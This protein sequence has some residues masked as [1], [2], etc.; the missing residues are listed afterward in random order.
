MVSFQ[1]EPSP[2]GSVSML[3][4]CRGLI[5]DGSN[6]PTMPGTPVPA[7]FPWLH[8]REGPDQLPFEV[9]LIKGVLSAWS[10]NCLHTFLDGDMAC[11]PCSQLASHIEL[12]AQNA[13]E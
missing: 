6:W 12:L 3:D 5:L 7:N 10:P 4:T 13:G 11:F 1:R 2:S 9:E 8:M